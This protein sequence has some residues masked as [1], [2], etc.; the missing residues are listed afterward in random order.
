MCAG[1]DKIYCIRRRHT[2]RN[3]S[4]FGTRRRFRHNFF[5]SIAHDR[6]PPGTHTWSTSYSAESAESAVLPP[7]FAATV[8]S[9][10]VVSPVATS[11]IPSRKRLDFQPVEPKRQQKTREAP[12][13]SR[14]FEPCR[15][16]HARIRTTVAER[17]R[18]GFRSIFWRRLQS[19]VEHQSKPTITYEHCPSNPAGSKVEYLPI[20][21]VV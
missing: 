14:G 16:Q 21:I 5:E 3:F 11:N 17:S 1:V 18:K 7:L 6:H 13:R 12:G 19:C 10:V 2:G 20:L 9:T 15:T 8:N 4:K